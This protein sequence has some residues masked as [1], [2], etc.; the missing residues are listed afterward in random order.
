[1]SNL[2]KIFFSEL[3]AS[4][5]A[6]A[7]FSN[8]IASLLGISRSE[9]YNKI[10]AKSGLTLQQ[11]DSLCK[12]FNFY[13][14]INPPA[15]TSSCRIHFTPFH[16]GKANM[17]RY[18]TSL[19][20]DLIKL[21]AGGLQKLTCS[22]DDIPIFHLFKYPQLTAFKLFFW[23]SRISNKAEVFTAASL[24]TP[25]YKKL[26]NTAYQM[27]EIYQDIPCVEIWNSSATLISL[28][29]I[30]HAFENN[31]ITDKR[32]RQTICDQLMLV[33]HDVEG[34]AIHSCKQGESKPPFEWYYC[35]VVSNVA[36]LADMEDSR[37]CF[38]RF[39]T[40]NNMKSTDESI[41]DE[42]DFWLQFLLNESVGFS[43]QG[44]HLRN[45]YLLSLRKQIED[46]PV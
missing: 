17:E 34:Y 36:F 12:H 45:K 46:L 37:A 2:Q 41:C 24:K 6:D 4:L 1:M 20:E 32:L 27:Y 19:Y 25:K 14:Q 7:L 9:A 3:K 39:N 26:L 13:F 10:S 5:P 44:S 42:V 38:L 18:I 21:Q 16:Q 23:N 8:Q 22:T 40:F 35:D 11:M 15:Q 33:L 28:D 29:Q 31:M 43:G 30:R